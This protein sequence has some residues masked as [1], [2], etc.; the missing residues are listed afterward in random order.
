MKKIFISSFVA[1]IC[2]IC[3]LVACKKNKDISNESGD[4]AKLSTQSV[5]A[6][7]F[8]T[9]SGT[10]STQT[11]VNTNV[12][13]LSGI[14]VIPSGV[15]VTINAGTVIQGI[16]SATTAWLVI[17]KGGKLVA[18]GTSSNPIIFTS[19][20]AA[21]S[22]APGDWGGIAF[23][24]NAPSNV[25]PTLD[26]PLSSGYTL[27]GGASTSADNSG[28]LRFVQIHYGGKGYTSNESKA[29]L[30]LNAVGSGTTI[31][32][33]QV[34]NSLYDG[35]A[36]Y[37]GTVK[38]TN[39]ISYNAGRTD[40]PIS[41]G[42]TGKMQFLAAMRLNNSASPAAP[43]YGLEIS[44]QLA[45]SSAATPLTLPVISNITVQGPNYCS[46]TAVSS[47]FKYA[48]H[49]FN[50]GAG[51]IYNSVFSSWNN[52][53]TPSGLLID[54]AGSI[55]KTASNDLEFSYNSFDNSGGTPY[56]NGAVSWSSSGCSTSMAL[57]ITPGLPGCREAGNQFS[58]TTLG[59]D[60]SFC[61]DYCATGFS[62]NFV[63][64]TTTMSS[65]NFTWDTGSAFSHVTYRGAFGATD[66]TQSW[67]EWCA[68]NKDYCL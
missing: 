46:G 22:R 30:L 47:N 48:V 10:L 9:L 7:N 33:V 64:G 55:A 24:G 34:S 17:E 1:I 49:Y 38:L 65:P 31:D 41:Y 27:S 61:N 2:V 42:Y 20:Q 28:S 15:T 58:V 62:R 45:S 16:K 4:K 32:H 51:K 13:K 37:G 35:I 57:W 14:V 26:I 43:A 60:A 68:Q 54:D 5:Q 29:A 66:F 6:C 56:S 18:T 53:V 52:S 36:T 8:V 19:D 63:L 39:M 67:T 12:Y 59:Y 23:A 21:G 50:N 44:N 3:I 11:L 40:I 25:S